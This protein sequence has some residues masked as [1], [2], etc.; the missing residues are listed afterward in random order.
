M[1]ELL[2]HKTPTEVKLVLNPVFKFSRQ[3]SWDKLNKEQTFFGDK[4]RSNLET[5]Q[6]WKTWTQYYFGTGFWQTIS[7]GSEASQ[8]QQGVWPS[9]LR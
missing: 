4:K 7:Y 3:M 5:S 9:I 1:R 8:L 2:D 6:C